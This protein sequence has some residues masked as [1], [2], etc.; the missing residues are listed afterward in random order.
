M[1]EYNGSGAFKD[2]QI[3][4]LI[5]EWSASASEIFAGAIQDNDR[6]IIIGR[7]SFGK[8]LVQNQLP[9]SD[10]SAIRLTI[11]RY[12]TPSGRSIQKEYEMGHGEDYEKDIL[13]R[14]IHGEFD[15]P[16]SIKQNDKLVY[17]TRLGRTVYGGGGIMPDLF[18]PVDTTD[19]TRYFLEVSGRNIPDIFVPRDTTGITPYVNEVVNKGL[20][21]QYAFQYSD[22]KRN[23]LSEYKDHTSLQKYLNRQPLL[24]EFIT[25]ASSHGV[26]RNNK[27]IRE[28]SQL[29]TN[30]I[31]SYIARN[32]IGDNAFYPIFLQEDKTFLKA[33]DILNANEGFPQAPEK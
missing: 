13:N 21:Y 28:S 31:E 14:F 30:Y 6:G 26:K 7:R 11:A 9:F 23:I 4:V 33:L 18:V 1:Q 8:G 17:K 24:Q 3:V 12:Y 2:A 10:G 15:N 20:L 19:V 29:L 32:I 5:D 27:E 16:D 25:F 22:E